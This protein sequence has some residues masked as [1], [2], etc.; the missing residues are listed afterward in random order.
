[1]RIWNLRSSGRRSR[2]SFSENWGAVLTLAISADDKMLVFGCLDQTVRLWDLSGSSPA[3]HAVLRGHLGIVRLV[4]F[5]PDGRS[6]LSV[7]DGGRVIAWDVA[8]GTKQR[9]WL[10]P[11]SKIYSVAITHDGR[12]LATGNSDGS[13]FLFRLY[14]RSEGQPATADAILTLAMPLPGRA[15]TR[16]ARHP[17][18]PESRESAC[19]DRSPAACGRGFPACA[20]RGRAG[21]GWWRACR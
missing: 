17:S 7:C 5:N 4:Q 9:E 20:S 8:T 16:P 11:R 21:A 14:P 2:P 1:M 15:L 18:T 12:Y 19:R 6:V 13:V 10:L 3:E